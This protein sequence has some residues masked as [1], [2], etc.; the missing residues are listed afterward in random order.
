MFLSPGDVYMYGYHYLHIFYVSVRPSGEAVSG[1]LS[2]L[3]QDMQRCRDSSFE[4]LCQTVSSHSMDSYC[5]G[6]LSDE[7]RP[8]P[9]RLNG[10][11][12]RPNGP[13][14]RASIKVRGHVTSRVNV[15]G[16]LT[17][18]VKVR[19]HVT[20]RVKVGGHLTVC[21]KVRGHVT[22]RVKVD[23]CL[24]IITADIHYQSPFVNTQNG[25]DNEETKSLD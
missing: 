18:C 1:D 9:Q 12:Q 6:R 13:L 22:S 5:S 16:N 3:L 21:V 24:V 7:E 8:D 11:P 2:K 17:V 23:F 15:R 14:G 10:G 25:Q 20:S 4:E 19:G